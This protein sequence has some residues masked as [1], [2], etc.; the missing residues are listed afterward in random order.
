MSG[1]TTE[2][3]LATA[4]DGDDNADYLTLNL[5]NSLRT[6]DALF[7]NVS[8]HNHGA[9]H[10]GG[11]IAAGAIANGT[12]TSAMLADGTIVTADI[13]PN[14]V[15]QLIGSYGPTT[16]TFSSTT[17]GTWL[18]TPI[19]VTG[20]AQGNPVRVYGF[21]TWSHSASGAAVDVGLAVDGALSVSFARDYA[22]FAA[23]AVSVAFDVLITPSVGSH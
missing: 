21:L 11:Q 3:N 4:V 9:A 23:A 12:I 2:L 13:A 15:S 14:A 16:P 7:N 19:T 20:A 6:L 17:T 8:G 10:N 5:A 18:N 22:P 1:A